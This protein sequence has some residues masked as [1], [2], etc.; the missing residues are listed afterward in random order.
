VNPETASRLQSFAINWH[1][2]AKGFIVFSREDCA[3]FAHHQPAG[4]S[5]GSSGVMTQQGFA[6]LVWREDR[7]FLVAH[8]GAEQPATVEQLD[9]IRRFSADLKSALGAS[10]AGAC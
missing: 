3:A 7:A 5:L 1:T 9:A 2:N 8:G 4:L 10:V 6:Y